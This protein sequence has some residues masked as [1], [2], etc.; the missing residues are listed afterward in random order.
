[1]NAGMTSGVGRYLARSRVV[2]PVFITG[3]QGSPAKIANG[4]WC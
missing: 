1:M 3:V 2:T 4:E